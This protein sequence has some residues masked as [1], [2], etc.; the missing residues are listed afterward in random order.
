MQIWVLTGLVAFCIAI[1]M[2]LFKSWLVKQTKL[3]EAINTL[4][5]TIA[6]QN[7]QVKTLFNERINNRSD[8]KEIYTRVSKLE[9]DL[10]RCKNYE[11]L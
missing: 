3:L 10:F 5:Q 11:E 1:L 4:K 7:E 6:V 8:I 9:K 2:I